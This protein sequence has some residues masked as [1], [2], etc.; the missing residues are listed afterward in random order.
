MRAL[1]FVR[2]LRFVTI[3]GAGLVSGPTLAADFYDV[4]EADL[5]GAPGTIIRTAPLEVYPPGVRGY[6]VLYR[7]T[8]LNGEPIAVSGV[9][10]IPGKKAANR[11]VVA[12]AHPTTGVARKCAPSLHHAPLDTIPGLKDMMANGYVVTAT[13]YPGLG[14]TGPHPYLVGV[15]EGRA[16]LDSVRAARAFAEASAG[17][18]FAVWG[19]SQGGHAALFAGELAATYAKDLKLV[20]VARTTSRRRRAMA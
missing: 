10:A 20:G 5:A 18:H 17:E 4:S 19:H 16:V 14:T 12:W 3:L 13:D 7:S 2:C 6:R 11:P 1:R 9:I 15:S 8:G